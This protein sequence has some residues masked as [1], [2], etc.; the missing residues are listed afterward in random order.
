MMKIGLF[1][2]PKLIKVDRPPLPPIVAYDF[3][4]PIIIWLVNTVMDANIIKA[5]ATAK[6]IP[7]WPDFIAL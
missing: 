3:L 7:F 1:H 6:P 5:K 4:F 2:F